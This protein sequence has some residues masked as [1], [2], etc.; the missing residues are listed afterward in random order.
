MQNK[1]ILFVI[2]VLTRGGAEVQVL[3][4]ARGMQSRGW[5]V[6][7]VS[8]IEPESMVEPFEQSGI[9]VLCLG[10]KP[11]I[12]NPM[13]IL[14]LRKI[15]SDLRPQV[16]HSHILHANVLARITR[17]LASF[18]VLVCTAHNIKESG[19]RLERL[20]QYTDGMADLTTNVSQAGVDR[21]I[22]ASLAPQDRIRFIPNGLDLSHFQ[23]SPEI[24]ARM[25]QALD[26]GDKFVWLGIG[27]FEDA[28]D[29]PNMFR[30]F[31]RVNDPNSLL[32]VVG[33]G[34]KEAELR[35]F[36]AT[37]SAADRTRFLGV[38]DDVQDVMTA[39]DGYVM[40]SAWEG[41]PLVLQEASAVGLPVVATDVGGNREVVLDGQTGLL[42]PAKDSDRL[43]GAMRR[44]MAMSP[45]D[46][47]AM[48][49]RGRE[50]VLSHYSMNH[51]LDLWESI[52]Q[53]LLEKNRSRACA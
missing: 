47:S 28:K 4:L 38:R 9:D 24:R 48:G 44:L 49:L 3:R 25:R 8:M 2:N 10:M 30:A 17:V 15:I 5:H 29:Y 42:V 37:T 18:P 7:V 46:R 22:S 32:L 19:K 21:Y 14:R 40:S 34:S 13:A 1:S 53:E 26:L 39:A 16:V 41:M 12:P 33:R 27:R 20:Y 11:G 51:V 43:S 45:A 31:A 23:P 52:Y 50:H 6:T 36:A 35:E